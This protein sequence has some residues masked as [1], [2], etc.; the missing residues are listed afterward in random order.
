MRRQT[1]DLWAA[2]F[3]VVAAAA[4]AITSVGTFELFAF[5]LPWWLAAAAT[6]VLAVGIPLLKF[7]ATFDR[8]RGRSYLAIMGGFLLVELVA[9]YFKAQ[10]AFS[11]T[12][13]ANASLRG[14]DLAAAAADG[15]ASRVL[16]FLFLASLPLVVVVMTHAA[17]QRIASD[18]TTSARVRAIVARSRARLAAARAELAAS[19]AEVAQSRGDLTAARAELEVVRADLG[20][21]RAEVADR[22]AALTVS[23]AQTSSARAEVAAQAAQLAQYEG[24]LRQSRADLER[25]RSRPVLTVETAAELFIRA[26]APESTVR[27]WRKRL[28]SVETIEGGA[29]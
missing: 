1:I 20:E 16:A 13:A 28:E 6:V 17:A 26:G 27:G 25:E 3:L 15:V 23:I 24:W 11:A 29:A 9:Q 5:L 8:R 7:A 4:L 14:S 12:V 19:R 10:S 18:R 22:R 2:G 21:A